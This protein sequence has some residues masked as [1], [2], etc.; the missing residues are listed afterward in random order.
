MTMRLDV[1]RIM[2]VVAIAGGLVSTSAFADI[3][4]WVDSS[5]HLNVS[6]QEPPDGVR[7]TNVLRASPAAKAGAEAARA[8]AQRAELQALNQRVE[9]LE[10]DLDAASQVAPMPFAYAPAIAAAVPPVYPTFVTQTIVVPSA[11]AGPAPPPAYGDCWD[12]SASCFQPGYYGFYP[13]GVV[14]LSTAKPGRPLH[15]EHAHVPATPQVPKPVGLLP[16]P[17]NL[18]PNARRP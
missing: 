5:G 17:P 6:N 14:V 3:Y 13:S 2:S 1:H 10:R 9:E 12:G 16:D 18:F 7:V 11:P 15:R 8:A 4:T